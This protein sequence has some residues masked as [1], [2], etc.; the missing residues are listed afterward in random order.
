[1]AAPQAPQLAACD[2]SQLFVDQRHESVERS[3]ITGVMAA[4]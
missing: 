4:Q 2:R 3:T 1:M